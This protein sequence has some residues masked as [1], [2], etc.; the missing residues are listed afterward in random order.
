MILASGAVMALAPTNESAGSAPD[1]LPPEAQSAHVDEL[2][3]DFPSAGVAPVIAVVTRTDGA[4]LTGADVVALTGVAQRMRAVERGVD[5]GPA[6]PPVIS[7]D[8]KAGLVTVL[9]K[10]DV[11]GFEL[12]D[13]VGALRTVASDGLPPGLTS[14]ITGGPAFGADIADS[15]SGANTT[16]LLV[17]ALVVAVLLIITYRSPILWLVPLIVVAIADRLATVV[18]SVVAGWFGLSFDGSTS[19]ITSVLVFGAGTNYALLLVSRY[20][21]ELRVHADHR[22]ALRTAWL[23]AAPAILA[24][25]ATVV[26]ALLLLLVTPL[27]SIRSLGALAACGI[28]IAAIFVLIALPGALALCGRGLFWP[29]VP[30]DG[31]ADPTESG[32]WHRVATTVAARPVTI[33]AI[34]LLAMSVCAAGLIGVKV[35]LSQ[36][37]QFRVSADSVD[38]YNVVAQHF[39]KGLADPVTVVARTRGAD[40]VAKAASRVDGVQS[41]RITETAPTGWTRIAVVIDADPASAR[42]FDTIVSLRTAVSAVP[43][44]DAL[45]GG[46]DAKEYDTRQAARRS[47]LVVIPLILAVLMLILMVLLRAIVLPLLLVVVTAFSA[48]TALG[49]GTFLSEHVFGFGALDTN[50]ILFAFLFLVALGVD[51]TYFLVLRAREEAVKRGTRDGM[52]RAVSA[53]GGVITSAG[54]VLAAVFV[55]LG[56]LPLITLTQL[57]IIVGLGI[58]IDTFVVRTCVVPC[59]I[60]LAGTDRRAG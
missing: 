43:G 14:N 52:I 44:G 33:A 30:H 38:G 39:S 56:V 8:K 41:V 16:L 29:V 3:D 59:L 23:R 13:M 42:A 22:D 36:T 32:V 24:S 4:Q 27:P 50:V 35:G 25:N 58:L 19:G 53:T 45:V 60:L 57:G 51:Y 2:L 47:A 1:S 31:D 28:V 21:E 7:D 10:G 48:L 11:T 15:F 55:V 49:A 5:A 46:S 26:V 54:V 40:A 9:V 12:R 18:G 17:T 20:R 6:A 34:A 37:E